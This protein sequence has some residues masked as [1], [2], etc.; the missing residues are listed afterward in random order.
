MT[1]CSYNSDLEVMETILSCMDCK[2]MAG[3]NYLLL[4][5]QGARLV[6]HSLDYIHNIETHSTAHSKE[7]DIPS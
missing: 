1:D 7:F 4:S 2:L 6:F 5:S 3:L